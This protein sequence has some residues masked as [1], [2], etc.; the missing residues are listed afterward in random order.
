M[1]APQVI[2]EGALEAA[3][4]LPRPSR[5]DRALMRFAPGYAARRI[6]AK[7]QAQAAYLAASQ[8]ESAFKAWRT[9]SGGPDEALNQWDRAEIRDRSHDVYRNTP[10]GRGIVNT[11]VDSVVGIGLT[12]RPQ[13]A[14]AVLGISRDAARDWGKQALRWWHLWANSHESDATRKSP[15]SGGLDALAWRSVL[16]SGDVLAIRRYKDRGTPFGLCYQLVEGHRVANPQDRPESAELAQGV[17]LDG[18]GEVVSYFVGEYTDALQA[19]VF[20]AL[21]NS[22]EVPAYTESGRVLARLLFDRQ[23]PDQRRGEPYLAP[24]MY[25][26]KQISRLSDAELMGAVVAAY[27]TVFVKSERNALA[28]WETLS[29]IGVPGASVTPEPAPGETQEKAPDYALG[30]GAVVGLGDDEDIVIADPKRPNAAFEPFFTAMCTQ[31]GM[32]TG[33]PREILMKHFGTSYTAARAAILEAWRFYRSRRRFLTINLHSWAYESLIEE[34][35][36]RGY[37]SAPGFFTDPIRRA[38]W[39]RAAWR[40]PS[41]GQINPKDEVEAAALRI[42]NQLSTH[43]REVAESSGE[44]WNETIETLAEESELAG[45]LQVRD[46]NADPEPALPAGGTGAGA[47]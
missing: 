19:G 12:P 11:N 40:G 1:A 16:L 31:I 7:I 2:Q 4:K 43:E 25:A 20:G 8:T 18:D 36:A 5:F 24:V 14:A 46:P 34:A 35:V 32:G 10:L 39:L 29:N 30:H 41:P 47:A 15:F 9:V 13:P 21:A 28:T 37:L 26:L 23:R 6:R 42:E 33:I 17:L 27:F 45:E 22:V 38:A 3:S 44:D